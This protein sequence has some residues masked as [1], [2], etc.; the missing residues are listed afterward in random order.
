MTPSYLRTFELSEA[1]FSKELPDTELWL[2]PRSSCSSNY[3]GGVI[4]SIPG[5]S[6][7]NS[8][9]STW[10]GHSSPYV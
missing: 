10:L 4:S 2:P 7:Y 3:L 8:I 5:F 1:P 9:W 6:S